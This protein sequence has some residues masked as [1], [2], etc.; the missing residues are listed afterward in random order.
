MILFS[1]YNSLN[2]YMIPLSGYNFVI[3]MVKLLPITVLGRNCSILL[4]KICLCVSLKWICTKWIKAFWIAIWVIWFNPK[5]NTIS[6]QIIN[7]RRRQFDVFILTKFDSF[8]DVTILVWCKSS[9][10]IWCIAI[11]SCWI[12]EIPI[13]FIVG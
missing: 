2:Y 9:S 13:K 5:S 7:Y 11:I 1:I 4:G 8:I 10:K 12:Y 3:T 6:S